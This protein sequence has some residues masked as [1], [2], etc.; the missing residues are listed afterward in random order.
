MHTSELNN[1]YN[2]PFYILSGTFDVQKVDAIASNGI[3]IFTV[4]FIVNST[5]QGCLIIFKCNSSL[6]DQM[7]TLPNVASV[8]ALVIGLNPNTYDVLVYDVEETGLP[9]EKPAVEIQH[10]KVSQGQEWTEISYFIV[11]T[12]MHYMPCNINSTF[13]PTSQQKGWCHLMWTQWFLR[14]SKFTVVVTM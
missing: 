11:V 10:T 13:I 14:V 1:T 2:I 8:F 5:A 7:V 4:H 9:N 12:T 3:L 6:P